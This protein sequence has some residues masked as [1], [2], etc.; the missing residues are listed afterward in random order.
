MIVGYCTLFAKSMAVVK[1]W[2]SLQINMWVQVED[3]SP[4][5]DSRLQL[6]IADAGQIR[7]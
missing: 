4:V 3:Q 1:T 7:S 2:Q 5:E 6:E